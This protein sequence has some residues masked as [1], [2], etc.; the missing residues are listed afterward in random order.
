MIVKGPV[1]TKIVGKGPMGGAAEPTTT[2]K[3][4]KKEGDGLTVIDAE[5]GAVFNRPS[6][7]AGHKEIFFDGGVSVA[8]PEFDMVDGDT[9]TAYTKTDEKTGESVMSSAVM[10]GQKVRVQERTGKQREG[11]ARAVAFYPDSGD[12]KLE[13]YPAIYDG[14]Q[15]KNIDSPTG[16]MFLNEK[17]GDVK[18]SGGRSKM[19]FQPGL[20][21]PA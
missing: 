4:P 16:V 17:T 1:R 15:W 13:G 6:S 2:E 21:P 11:T 18:G 20:K 14:I 10:R 3:K 12:I 8:D 9:L 5:R 19:S 7:L